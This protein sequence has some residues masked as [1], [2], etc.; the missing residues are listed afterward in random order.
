MQDLGI[1]LRSDLRILGKMSTQAYYA[2]EHAAKSRVCLLSRY[3]TNLWRILYD[4]VST[5]N[6]S[7]GEM[8]I[9]NS[10]RGD[11]PFFFTYIYFITSIDLNTSWIICM[12]S[13]FISLLSFYVKTLLH[14]TIPSP[15]IERNTHRAMCF[16]DKHENLNSTNRTAIS[17]TPGSRRVIEAQTI[18]PGSTRIETRRY[19]PHKICGSKLDHSAQVPVSGHDITIPAASLTQLQRLTTLRTICHSSELMGMH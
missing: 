17:I 13:L 15:S 1:D 3:V 12:D 2:G 18:E 6:S 16:S 9:E 11:A 4:Q 19:C 14:I 8:I 7:K 5:K 10:Y